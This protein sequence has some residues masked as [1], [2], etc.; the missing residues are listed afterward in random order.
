MLAGESKV[1]VFEDGRQHRHVESPVGYQD[2][3]PIRAVPLRYQSLDERS[4]SPLDV[5][6]ALSARHS[7]IKPLMAKPE[8]L[9]LAVQLPAGGVCS[10]F[11]DA[12]APLLQCL[13]DLKRRWQ[14]FGQDLRGLHGA[15]Q[16]AGVDA[17]NLKTGQAA[18]QYVRLLDARLGQRV[19]G[20][21][22][23]EF[24]E[25]IGGALTVTHEIEF[26]SGSDPTD[27]ATYRF[28]VFQ[29]FVTE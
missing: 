2:D 4:K 24:S 3:V 6:E 25:Q 14:A 16:W 8:V 1:D 18:Q 10:A 20:S 15:H 11:V 9:H 13:S 19:F 12:H 22:V 23:G 26:H 21:T 28:L 5:A 7:A 17:F 27:P 29:V